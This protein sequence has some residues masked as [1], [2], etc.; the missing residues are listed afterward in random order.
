M[1][2]LA[3]FVVLGVISIVASAVPASAVESGAGASSE[4]ASAPSA[5][6]LSS[7]A[8]REA[9]Q[10]VNAARRAGGR[11]ALRWDGSLAAVARAHS[12]T[13]ATDGMLAHN[14]RLIVRVRGWRALG[15]NVGVG[16]DA[17]TVLGAMLAS[18]GH[19]ANILGTFTRTGIGAAWDAD[20]VLWVTQVFETPRGH[21][22]S[23]RSA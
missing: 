21:S 18:A 20:G 7:R 13:M 4:Q 19:R 6:A 11:R 12:L 10:L 22:R 8:A 2:K 17:A 23:R 15:E 1:R 9:H 3:L 14:P 16:P 5:P